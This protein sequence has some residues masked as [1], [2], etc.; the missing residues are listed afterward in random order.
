M[1]NTARRFYNDID[2]FYGL[3]DAKKVK[4]TW[5]KNE[6][7]SIFHTYMFFAPRISE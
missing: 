5:F 2:Y 1:F 4:W 7:G 3:Y 6:I